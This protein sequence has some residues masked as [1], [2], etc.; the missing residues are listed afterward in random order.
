MSFHTPRTL[1]INAAF[2]LCA[3][4]ASHAQFVGVNSNAIGLRY[5]SNIPS[6]T[7]TVTQNSFPDVLQFQESF[8]MRPGTDSNVSRH[9]AMLSADLGVTPHVVPPSAAWEFGV[10]LQISGESAN[11]GGL[12]IGSLGPVRPWS[13]G[14]NTGVLMV[15]P[16]TREIA[17]FGGWLPFFSNF[18]PQWSQFG[19]ANR[20]QE[21]TLRIR[22]NPI[23]TSMV[24]AEYIIN[25]LSTG[26]LSLDSG[27]RA[28]YFNSP[29]SAGVY[30]QNAWVSS[31]PSTATTTFTNYVLPAPAS[32]PV[33]LSALALAARRR[34]R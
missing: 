19:L 18:Q 20:D 25:G 29:Q 9:V 34:R 14:A 33:L 11:E 1:A 5:A 27:A 22:V 32:A 21:Y 31:G 10:S 15:N 24:T 28:A 2:V 6:S 26:P 8:A 23:S 3:A 16:S 17:A 13:F 12:H 7:I 30:V 4:V